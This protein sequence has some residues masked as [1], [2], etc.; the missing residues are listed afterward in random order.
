MVSLETITLRLSVAT[1]GMAT[2]YLH[3]KHVSAFLPIPKKTMLFGHCRVTN[4]CCR[5]MSQR[6]AIT[7]IPILLRQVAPTRNGPPT[8]TLLLQDIPVTRKT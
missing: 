1:E 6:T 3:R 4:S 2:L 8:A 5:G 7:L